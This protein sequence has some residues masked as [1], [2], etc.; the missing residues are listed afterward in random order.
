M[1]DDIFDI[2]YESFSEAD[3]RK[4]GAAR[5]AEDASTVILIF[6]ISK[7][8]S[9]PLVWDIYDSQLENDAALALLQE[10]V[11]T[12]SRIYAHNYQFEHFISKYNLL[13]QIK[14]QA[15]KIE[16]WRCTAAMARRGA[17]PFSLEDCAEFLEL[18]T[19]KDKT[20]KL[21]IKLFSVPRRIMV[22]GKLSNTV[23]RVSGESDELYTLDGEKVRAKDAWQMFCE[24][25]RQD[26]RTQIAI[27]IKLRA[28]DM[29]AK[30]DG[31]SLAS[32]QF[33]A[34]LNDCGVPL[35]I[36]A[37]KNADR[38]INEY[39]E[40]I[41]EIFTN[42]T[43]LR[44]TQR[45]K[46]LEWLKD[47]GYPAED[48]QAATVIEVK[49]K[50]LHTM[51]AD[52]VE[53]L[54]LYSLLSF[55][56]IKKVP[57]MIGA[58]NEDGRV[59][60][61]V[62]WAGA[63]RTHR[64]TGRIIQPQ[65]MRKPSIED[66]ET[67]YELLQ[68][69]ETTSQ[70]L[71]MMWDSPLEVIASCIRHFIDEPEGQFLDVDY[72]SI[73][74]RIL[75]WLA[76]EEWKLELFRSDKKEDE[77]YRVLAGILFNKKP[78][79]VTKDERFLGK[80]GELGCG[81]ATGI[82]KFCEM[83]SMFGYST[84]PE[85]VEKFW[86]AKKETIDLYNGA[87]YEIN[88]DP[89]NLK[90]KNIFRDFEGSKLVAE[91]G[92]NKTVKYP[93]TKAHV[94]M[95]LQRQLAAKVVTTFREQ[96]PKVVKLWKE[97]DTHA[98]KAIENKGQIFEA[99]NGKIKFMVNDIGYEALLM[100]LPSGHCLV[101]PKPSLKE[102]TKM[103]KDKTTGQ[104]REWKTTEILFYGQIPMKVAWG[105]VRTFGARLVE[106]ACQAIGGDFLAHGTVVAEKQGYNTFAIIHDQALCLYEP[107]KGHTIEG[108]IDALC[109]LPFWAEDFPLAGDG[110]IVNYYTKD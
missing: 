89:N 43:G 88:K 25:C 75:A 5:Y 83:L 110:G 29:D 107:E 40:R 16:Q 21:L 61:S 42:L 31:S 55:A 47:G 97:F 106:N 93:I 51:D 63:L 91:T 108:Y 44:H 98:K 72:S 4:F 50:H 28:F 1:T 46:V 18:P 9:E 3:L 10:A 96:N 92:S 52:A 104:P 80:T 6:A 41:G 76:G 30:K 36:P 37:L 109:D 62:M 15:P 19:Q 85:Q 39:S 74:A 67:A 65:N 73:E 54:D 82:D 26:V 103:Y 105:N 27:R 77:P 78:I 8:G 17:V 45:A 79:D 14:I 12:N 35:N 24:Y 101:Y 34:R 70:D 99:A 33:D 59:R 81:Y 64:W 68:Q 94:S 66:T 7:N 69:P 23:G 87:V 100:K 84:P 57:T 60:G 95:F 53:A 71:G 22:D 102:V 13:D 86:E 90:S 20:G 48:M 38:I 58:A 49:E 2:D 32:F 11:D 56:A